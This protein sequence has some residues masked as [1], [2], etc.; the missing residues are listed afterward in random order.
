M[1]DTANA[2]LEAVC[3]T[4]VNMY[5]DPDWASF[6]MIA[7]KKDYIYDEK[8]KHVYWYC[9]Y[10][11]NSDYLFVW[12]KEC[13]KSFGPYFR[14][15]LETCAWIKAHLEKTMVPTGTRNSGQD[16]HTVG[17]AWSK[18]TKNFNAIGIGAKDHLPLVP[19]PAKA[20]TTCHIF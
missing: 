7:A 16:E 8:L 20:A 19:P 11:L 4:F 1:A 15:N 17:A 6:V 5:A 10:E 13:Q 18:R 14:D 3:Q 9:E 2:T 12:I